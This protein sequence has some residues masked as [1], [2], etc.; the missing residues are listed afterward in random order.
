[1]NPPPNTIVRKINFDENPFLSQTMLDV[2]TAMR[3]EDDDEYRHVYLGEP[4]SDD[5]NVVIKRKW[6]L[7]ALNAHRTLKM[8]IVGSKRLGFDIADGGAD[9]CA[10]VLAH[11]SL[12][13]WSDQWKADPD[14][15]LKSTTRAWDK[16]V[17]EKARVIYDNIG[18]GAMAGA[19]IIEL[20]TAN[21]NVV[22]VEF[23]GFNAGGKIIR[24]EAIYERSRRK[25]K[26]MFSNLKAQ[27]WW[28]VADRLRNTY[29]FVRNGIPSR[30]EDM[31]FIDPKIP[32]IEKLLDELSTPKRD[33]NE[34]G[35]VKVESK[36]DLANPRR[37]GGA[38]A[39]PNLAD[40]FVMAFAPGYGVM[41][42]NPDTVRKLKHGAKR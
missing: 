25:N 20:N 24:P 28:S 4:R 15:L 34:A 22:D 12:A 16:A 42:I 41:S 35:Q 19:K 21:R 5:E 39:S 2:I 8:E 31:I 14:E 10:L 27:S 37:D 40:A 18:V 7:A 3:D 11:G 1:M 9:K 13:T 30:Y 32:N 38:V 29:N 33:F 36:K 17:E 26:D 6:L 23:T